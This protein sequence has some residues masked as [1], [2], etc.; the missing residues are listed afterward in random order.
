MMVIFLEQQKKKRSYERLPVATNIPVESYEKLLKLQH[1]AGFET[2]SAVTR[3]ILEQ[4][5]ELTVV[6]RKVPNDLCKEN[7]QNQIR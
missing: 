5:I 3:A 1:S 4:A 2:I 6:E 7:V